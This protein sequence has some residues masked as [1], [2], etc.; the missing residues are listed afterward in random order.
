M[1]LEGAPPFTSLCLEALEIKSFFGEE[2]PF[3]ERRKKMGKREIEREIK[4]VTKI[5]IISG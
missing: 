4:R 3:H 5:Y 2:N 1:G